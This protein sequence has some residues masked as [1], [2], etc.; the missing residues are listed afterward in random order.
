MSPKEPATT[1]I[2]PFPVDVLEPKIF[3][4]ELRARST[5]LR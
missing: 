5:T 1:G 3:A 4:N 2:K